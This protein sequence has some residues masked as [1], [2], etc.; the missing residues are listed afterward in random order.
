MVSNKINDDLIHACANNKPIKVINIINTAK[1]VNHN[2]EHNVLKEALTF[3]Y[4]HS[5]K[6]AKI[7]YDYFDVIKLE[8]NKLFIDICKYCNIRSIKRITEVINFC[9][10][11]LPIETQLIGFYYGCSKSIK[12]VNY[13]LLHL[14]NIKNN[15]D[16][17]IAIKFAKENGKQD[18]VMRLNF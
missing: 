6:C 15:Y 12:I 9:N 2:I 10:H 3:A 14:K 4:K 13:L 8:I 16:H 7:L 17:N 5:K 1:Y 11:E 18:I